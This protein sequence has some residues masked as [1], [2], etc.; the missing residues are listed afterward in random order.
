MYYD[1]TAVRE[2]P[3]T[4]EFYHLIIND[5]TLPPRE[6][7]KTEEILLTVECNIQEALSSKQTKG[8]IDASFKIHFPYDMTMPFTL[9]R[10]VYFRG[11]LGGLVV[12]GEVIG[13][14]P[15]Q[16]GK[17]SVYIKDINV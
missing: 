12:R 2:F 7:E 9:K 10:G 11:N 8:F 6:Q 1:R 14:F 17:C 15:S 16:L 5:K 4:G 13:I 3:N